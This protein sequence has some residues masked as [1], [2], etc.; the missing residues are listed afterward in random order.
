[1][2]HP[3]S[4]QITTLLSDP[5]IVQAK[6]LLLEVIAEKQKNITA[7]RPANPEFKQGYQEIL[8]NFALYR[9]FPLWYPYLGS[10]FGNGSL[11]ELLDGSIKYDFIS[12]IGV[13][14]FGHSHPSLIE[15]NLHAALSDIPIQG[16][17][18]QNVECVELSELL[19]NA[20]KIPHCFLTTSGAMALEN[21]LK[22]A[23]QKKFP[24][25][26]LFAFERC[27]SGRTLAL[28]QVTDKAAYRDG[29]P[30][31][32][33]V[34]YVPFYDPKH[35]EESTKRALDTIKKQMTR[36]PKDH[37][38][39]IFELIQGEAGFYV[40]ST[41]FFSA[42]MDLLKENQVTI[43]IDE[44]QSF[45]RTSQLFAYQ[46]FDLHKYVDI[47]IVG[48][49]S[50]VCAT[51]FTDE[52]KPKPGLISQ[53]FISSTSAIYCSITILKMLLNSDLYGPNGKNSRFHSLFSK[54]LT[55]IAERHPGCLQ[56][57]FGVGSMIAFTP[58]N[59]ET[60]LVTKIAHALFEEGLIC[61][62]AGSNPTRIRMLPPVP[63]L[64]EDEIKA[65]CGLIETTLK[66]S[67]DLCIS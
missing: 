30:A 19:I 20:S 22:L 15:A 2:N 47:C 45:G 11:V 48:K 56:G 35:P 63:V 26:R 24:A 32:L 38:V 57:P 31:T 44:V 61:F 53:T 54:L 27:F 66:K 13:H 37:A 42:I 9:S 23:F 28:A 40:G 3:I 21:G 39:M 67:K 55:E 49:L 6:K 4:P 52:F 58:F 14:L 43:L 18:Q 29:L 62:I 64:S 60:A 10:G 59:G 25:R 65:A 8:D 46:H 34:D 36:Y 41:Q 17:L 50:Q 12:G 5:R 7:P 16:H 51:L 33:Q 1:M